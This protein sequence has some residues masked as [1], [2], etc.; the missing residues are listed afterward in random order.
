M[1]V[2]PLPDFNQSLART[3]G[4]MGMAD[5]AECHGVACGLICVRE[6]SGAA[7]FL[8]TLDLLQLTSGPG[9]ELRQIMSELFEATFSQLR[10]DQLR[11]ALWLPGDEESLDERTAALAQW[12]TGFLAGLGGAG[13]GLENLSQEAREALDDLQQ[14]ARA[15]VGG[16]VSDEDE[17]DAYYQVIEY[18]R[19]VTLLLREELRGPEPDD[20][21]H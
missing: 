4:E 20:R 2:K 21:I 10:D 18:I 1:P 17:E 11:L 3:R 13:Q 19:V 6:D 7:D 8:D 12:C 16:G 14:I 9:G 15:E 5:L